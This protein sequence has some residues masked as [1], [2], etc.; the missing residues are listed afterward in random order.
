MDWD[1]IWRDDND[2]VVPG[3]DEVALMMMDPTG[4]QEVPEQQ[5]CCCSVEVAPAVWRR[6]RHNLS[7]STVEEGGKLLGRITE[8]E[9]HLHIRIQTFID[10]GPRIRHSDVHLLPDGPYQEKVF[11]E[12]ESHDPGI[13]HIGT[14]HSHHCN[15]LDGL[16]TG[17]IK[18][19]F[20]SVNHPDYGS[21]YFVALLITA[22]LPRK[23]LRVRWYLFTR[24]RDDYEEIGA[25]SIQHPGG[26]YPFE[27]ILE[28]KERQSFEYR[29]GLRTR[30]RRLPAPAR[31]APAESDS[32]LIL[33]PEDCAWFSEHFPE[34]HCIR[35]RR[36]GA[37]AWRWKIHG[38]KE[39]LVLRFRYPAVGANNDPS[40]HGWLTINGAGKRTTLPITAGSGRFEQIEAAIEE[41][42]KRLCEPAE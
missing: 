5:G 40:V 27:Y 25:E 29:K 6:I 15:G 22:I 34:A 26:A 41:T 38:A 18:G 30:E 2:E 33:P 42:K 8:S 19:Y 36:D 39:R 16:S 1:A 11:H 35:D 20:W 21:D 31:T 24:G 9:G 12:V 23:K 14:W 10:S 17:D 3:E 32:G 37:L 28:Q 13:E 4:P 7:E